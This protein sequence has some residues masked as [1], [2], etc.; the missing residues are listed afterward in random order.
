MTQNDKNNLQ[1][2]CVIC[3]HSNIYFHLGGN[4]VYT[5]KL[6]NLVWKV[7]SKF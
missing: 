4:L 5:I 7:F 3:E 6:Q 1:A 2:T